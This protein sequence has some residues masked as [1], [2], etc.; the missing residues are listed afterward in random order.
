MAGFTKT[1]VCSFLLGISCPVAALA[2]S[3]DEIVQ[4]VQAEEKAFG[5]ADYSKSLDQRL[6]ALEIKQF[7]AIQSGS[8]SL[9]L[10]RICRELGVPQRE[11]SIIAAPF[12]VVIADNAKRSKVEASRDAQAQKNDKGTQLT[13]HSTNLKPSATRSSKKASVQAKR[14]QLAKA[15]TRNALS[16]SQLA[17][18]KV[19]N[20]QANDTSSPSKVVSVNQSADTSSSTSQI[21]EA[22]TMPGADTLGDNKSALYC[23]MVAAALGIVGICGVMIVYLQREKNELNLRYAR[24]FTLRNQRQTE[25]SE[26]EDNESE[27][28]AEPAAFEATSGVFGG[29]TSGAAAGATLGTAAEA[30]VGATLGAAAEATVGATIGAAAEAPVGATIGATIGAAAEAPVEAAVA[31]A[32]ES[33]LTSAVAFDCNS[34]DSHPAYL[35][36]AV[37]DA[38]EQLILH[39]ESNP[40]ACLNIEENMVFLSSVESAASAICAVSDKM[41]ELQEVIATQENIENHEYT[42]NVPSTT[43]IDDLSISWLEALS[44]NRSPEMN[45]PSLDSFEQL[46]SG[47][48][49]LKYNE[50][51]S[52]YLQ[53]RPNSFAQLLET[54]P[55]N[56]NLAQHDSSVGEIFELLM[57]DLID[58]SVDDSAFE[59]EDSGEGD[60]RL[61]EF[62]IAIS[63]FDDSSEIDSSIP[64]VWPAEETNVAPRI[65]SVS[66]WILRNGRSMTVISENTMRTPTRD[67]AFSASPAA[68]WGEESYHALAQLLIDAAGMT[69]FSKARS[70]RLVV[71]HNIPAYGRRIAASRVRESQQDSREYQSRLR[72]LFSEC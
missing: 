54:K 3:Y 55:S 57:T 26:F 32:V 28:D 23:A 2:Y 5:S 41:P 33:D 29:D 36:H 50:I 38:N 53:A 25:L 63:K 51:N 4:I 16:S 11:G 14:A 69:S 66:E 71:P 17:S 72:G 18:S 70:K 27:F 24:N 15:S 19:Q 64:A 37:I 20:G 39:Y 13:A 61:S 52:A 35:P 68:E 7:G 67:E 62:I 12:N 22:P 34:L 21:S 9:R 1:L 6:E 58:A 43:N 48:A 65:S 59:S 44:A 46:S 47:S 42:S 49:Q 40:F 30:T 45:G 60:Y 31:S 56:D 10:R 8:D